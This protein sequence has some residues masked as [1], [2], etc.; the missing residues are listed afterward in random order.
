[1]SRESD[2]AHQSLLLRPVERLDHASPRE[3]AR[4]IALVRHLMHLPQVEVVGLESPERL[5]ELP[6]GDLRIAPVGADLGHQEDLFPPS[7]RERLP[8]ADF[9]H[10]VMVFPR[11][12]HEADPRV[13]RLVQE[14]DRRTLGADHAEVIAAHAEGRDHLA[15]L[16]EQPAGN[17]LECRHA[18]SNGLN[19][20]PTATLQ[21]PNPRRLSSSAP[22]A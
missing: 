22:R 13:D 2:E 21:E 11:I 9:A 10:A 19:G 18:S 3:V 5:L 14:R 16:T 1:V 20:K 15:S 6:H 4:R 17:F 7:L 8:H 12:V